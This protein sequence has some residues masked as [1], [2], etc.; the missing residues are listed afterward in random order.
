MISAG[1]WQCLTVKAFWDQA[2]WDGRSRTRLTQP[3]TANSS[4]ARILSGSIV[5]WGTLRVRDFFQAN[6]WLGQPLEV[7]VFSLATTEQVV[8]PTYTARVQ[9]FFRYLPWEG[10]PVVARLP[11][12]KS[13]AAHFAP[14]QL[15]DEFTLTDLS[16][17]F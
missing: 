10:Q 5:D 16:D 15:D 1:S 6:N 4:Y 8:T 17:L 13:V 9:D 2:N 12:P 3:L 14:S 11:E 7:D